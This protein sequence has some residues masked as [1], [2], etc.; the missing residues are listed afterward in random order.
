M[1]WSAFIVL[2]F[3]CVI[4]FGAFG[5]AMAASGGGSSA[6]V[7]V[8]IEGVAVDLVVT[9]P[10]GIAQLSN[11]ARAHLGFLIDPPAGWGSEK[12]RAGAEIDLD[13]KFTDPSNPWGLVYPSG[14]CPANARCQSPAPDAYRLV[15]IAG[16]QALMTGNRAYPKGH[17]VADPDADRLYSVIFAGRITAPTQEFLF[18]ASVEPAS[19]GLTEVERAAV[20]RALDKALQKYE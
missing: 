3:A 8:D 9:A 12:P 11:E 4:A 13:R 16:R 5:P 7:P 19:R 2:F 18:F 15:A 6:R 14:I 1:R 17:R 20:R 10:S